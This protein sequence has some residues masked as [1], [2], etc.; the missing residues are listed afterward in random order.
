MMFPARF[1]YGKYVF[2]GQ[3]SNRKKTRWR[4]PQRNDDHMIWASALSSTRRFVD[5]DFDQEILISE[6]YQDFI[7]IIILIY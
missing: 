2:G 6:Y 4:W 1:E 5:Q 7:K 3:K